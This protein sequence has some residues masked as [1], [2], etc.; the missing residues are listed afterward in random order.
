MIDRNKHEYIHDAYD[1]RE[2]DYGELVPDVMM[3]KDGIAYHMDHR[4][5]GLAELLMWIKEPSH[6]DIMSHSEPVRTSHNTLSYGLAQIEL[7]L[8]SS[9][10]YGQ[11]MQ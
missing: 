5:L 6:P 4:N 7:F 1:F 9:K 11:L 8:A 3:I 2:T 10:L